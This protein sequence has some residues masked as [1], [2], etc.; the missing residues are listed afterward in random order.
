MRYRKE[1][2]SACF[3]E[4]QYLALRPSM[5]MVWSRFSMAS[6]SPT[7]EVVATALLPLPL[8]PL[9][10][11]LLVD[12]AVCWSGLEWRENVCFLKDGSR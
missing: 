11:R 4:R 8:A 3:M 7:A 2:K 6:S 9:L 12:K 1:R 5:S 10:Q